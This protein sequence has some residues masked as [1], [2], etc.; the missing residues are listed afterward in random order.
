M[1]TFH[2]NMQNSELDEVGTLTVNRLKYADLHLMSMMGRMR[3]AFDS[4]VIP[5]WKKRFESSHL[6]HAQFPKH[7]TIVNALLQLGIKQIS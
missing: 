7:C 5:S 2:S 1:S 3:A 4:N 6:S